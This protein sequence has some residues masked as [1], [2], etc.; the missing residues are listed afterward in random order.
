MV[1]EVN[2]MFMKKYYA[3]LFMLHFLILFF[4]TDCSSRGGN[5]KQAQ[6]NDRQPAVAG[7]FY[8][9][10]KSALEDSL[11]NMFKRAVPKKVEKPVIAVISPHAGYIFSGEVAASAFNQVEKKHY[12]DVFVIGSSHHDYYDGASIYSEGDF[13][14]PM[15]K[16]KVDKE[17]ANTLIKSNPCFVQKSSAHSLEHCIEVQ[18]PF[19]QYLL[20]DDINLVPVLIGAQSENTCKKIAEALKPYLNSDNLFVISTDFSHYPGYYDAQTSD[21]LAVQA[22]TLNSP[23]SFL[24]TKSDL[25]SSGIPNLATAV[26]GWTSVLTLLYMTEDMKGLKYIAVDSKN[27]GDTDYGDKKQVVGYNA[28][29]VT[30]N[31]SDEPAKNEFLTYNEKKRLLKIARETIRS[32]IVNHKRP[33]YDEKDLPKGLL[34]QCGAF[35]TIKENGELRGCIGSFSASEPLYK[36]VLEMAIASSTNDYRFNPVDEFEIDKLEIEISVLTPMRKIKSIDEIVLGKHGIYIKKGVHSG[37]FLP[38][39]GTETGWKKEDFLGHCAQD[40]AGIGWDG[41]KDADIFIY[42]AVVFSEKEFKKVEE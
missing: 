29:A 25:E 42:E 10:A 13:I 11:K 40:K 21:K 32:Y 2:E 14:M 7:K 41:W 36:T 34:Q 8:P 12:K 23:G 17:L 24:K 16:I 20:G 15:G 27:S 38:Q 30:Q 33:D 28:I 9:L 5:G 22:I 39:V 37:T 4:G 31:L 3:K 18:L 1:D 6:Q 35:V 19:L 26:C